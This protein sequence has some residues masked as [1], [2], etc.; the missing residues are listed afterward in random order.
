MIDAL[1]NLLWLVVLVTAFGSGWHF[2]R[3]SVYHEWRES[4]RE[5]TVKARRGL[6]E[7]GTP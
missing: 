5:A 1:L 4:L 6:A 3:A 7:K 2:G